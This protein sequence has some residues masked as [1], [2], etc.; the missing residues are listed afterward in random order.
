[1]GKKVLIIGAGI[2]GL[3]A[4]VYARQSG[5]DCTILEQNSNAGGICTSWK[6]KGFLFEGSIHWMIGTG[7]DEPLRRIWEETG[8]IDDNTKIINH[9]PF[10]VYDHHGQK[11]CLYRNIDKLRRHLLNISPQDKKYIDILYNDIQAF[12]KFNFHLSDL[13][14]LEVKYPEKQSL[15]RKIELLPM[16]T[17]LPRLY[18]ITTKEYV[19]NF[20][21]EGIRNMLI[22]LL[23]EEYSSIG[24]IYTLAALLRGDAGYV[25][26]GSLPMVQRMVD[27]FSSLGGEIRY[28]TRVD[29]LY[30]KGNRARGVIVD[31]KL[32][33]ADAIICACDTITVAKKLIEKKYLDNWLRD[34]GDKTMPLTCTFV[35][36]G[37]KADLSKYDFNTY[38]KVHTPFYCADKEVKIMGM[39]NYSNLEGFSATGEASVTIY[40][41]DSYCHEWWK[42]AKERGDY[43]AEKERVASCVIRELIRKFPQITEDSIA[44]VD[45]ATPLTYEKFCDTWN[46]SWMSTMQACAIPTNFPA[47]S[48]NILNVYFAGER[49]MPPGGLPVAVHTART[50]VQWLCKDNRS[51]FQ[52]NKQLL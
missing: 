27:K 51:V 45:V 43:K 10:L 26:G 33:K 44:A 1:M 49:I 34:I 29:K 15:L 25:D 32:M 20:K 50:A 14:G 41:L 22:S 11:I 28:K 12:K 37:I 17:K 4:G 46:G 31:N 5:Y 38:F 19:D 21:H 40:L 6:R 18:K 36:L 23:T 47:K 9:D 8:A 39:N 3:T 30:I 13:K 24:L 7:K 2:A 16:V 35:S 52:I 48:D 42:N